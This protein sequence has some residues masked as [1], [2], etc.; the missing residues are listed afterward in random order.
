M[1]YGYQLPRDGFVEIWTRVIREGA[2]F[3][4]FQRALE[5][6]YDD[7]R[8]PNSIMAA[9][10]RSGYGL[11]PWA[12]RQK[13]YNINKKLMTK[14]GIK[15]PIPGKY[16]LPKSCRSRDVWHNLVEKHNLLEFRC[17]QEDED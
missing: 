4:T 1:G 6:K 8:D 12:I 17:E 13:C 5:L 10:D 14:F 11:Y 3:G 15:L 9:N 7:Y 2:S 16:G